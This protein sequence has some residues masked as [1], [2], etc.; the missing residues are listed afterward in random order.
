M[1]ALSPAN[2]ERFFMT[3]N[4]GGH[5]HT[6]MCRVTGAPSDDDVSTA[7]KSVVN[8]L[9]GSLY[10][11]TFVK[12]EKSVITSNVR[13]PA[14]WTGDSS[15]GS[16]AEPGGGVPKNL[17][18]RG[19]DASGHK[20]GFSIYGWSGFQPDDWRI[21][22]EEVAAVDNAID[23]LNAAT[24]FFIS[25]GGGNMTWHNYANYSQNAYWQRALRG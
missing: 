8:A 2:T 4:V 1:T 13:N 7:I 12:F 3:Y 6:L 15:W 11:T 14:D 19:R 23:A 17:S 16:G 24:N 20:G 9:A 22:A 21:N 10:A 18:F 25:I 5:D